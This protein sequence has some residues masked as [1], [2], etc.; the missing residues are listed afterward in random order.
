MGGAG[1]QVRLFFNHRSASDSALSDIFGFVSQR[2]E[3]L[4][5]VRLKGRPGE[6]S[7]KARF[8]LFL[9]WLLPERFK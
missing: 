8:W 3:S 1:Q 4:Q 9:G 7:P 2:D 6:L 5:L